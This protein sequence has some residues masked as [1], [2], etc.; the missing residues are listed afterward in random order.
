MNPNFKIQKLGKFLL[1]QKAPTE[2]ITFESSIIRVRLNK[3]IVQ[4][5]FYYYF[6]TSRNGRALMSTIVEGTNIK[7]VRAS[8]LK[9]LKVPLPQ[10]IEQEGIATVLSDID[11]EITLLETKLT[12]TRQLKQGMMQELLTGRIRL[13]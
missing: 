3:R 9:R 7:G 2:P 11:A 10:R 4:P 6:F 13:I 12:K 8:E 5:Q 1:K